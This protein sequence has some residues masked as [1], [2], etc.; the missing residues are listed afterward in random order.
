MQTSALFD[1][2]TP[3]FSRF[4]VLCPH[5]KGRLSQCELGRGCQFFAILGGLFYG[6]PLTETTKLKFNYWTIAELTTEIILF[7]TFL[8]D[9]IDFQTWCSNYFCHHFT[10]IMSAC[11]LNCNSNQQ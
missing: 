4:M 7:H 2:K 9:L 8:K 6:R 1:V 11:R 5:E 3:D 10:P